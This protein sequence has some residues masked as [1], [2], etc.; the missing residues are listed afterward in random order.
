MKI[1]IGE[2][3]KLISEEV[4]R[5]MRWS[6]GMF[7]G[8]GISKSNKGVVEPPPGLGDESETED[9]EKD[10]GKEKPTQ[11]TARQAR[12]QGRSC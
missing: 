4:E 10:Y 2:L 7:M 8:G 12:R 11:F 6:A 3:K 1:T 9:T 5:N